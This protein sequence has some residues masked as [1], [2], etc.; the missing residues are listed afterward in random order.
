MW[1]GNPNY[2]IAGEGSAL[3]GELAGATGAD[4]AGVGAFNGEPAGNAT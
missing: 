2:G 1:L 4:E 3:W